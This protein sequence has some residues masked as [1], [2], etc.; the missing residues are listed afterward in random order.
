MDEK[1]NNHYIRVRKFSVLE[2][3]IPEIPPE[4]PE[5]IPPEIPEEPPEEPEE[6]KHLLA[7]LEELYILGILPICDSSYIINNINTIINN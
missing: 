5:E 7:E 6:H 2:E 3:V 4:I 1:I